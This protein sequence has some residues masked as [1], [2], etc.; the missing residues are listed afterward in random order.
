MDSVK[1]GFKVPEEIS[2]VGND[3][4]LQDS[5]YT[6]ELTTMDVQ[7]KLMAQYAVRNLVQLMNGE[8]LLNPVL[9]LEG[10]LIERHSVCTLTK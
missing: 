1:R 2:I 3:N 9:R 8:N 6:R 7:P 10:Q 4:F 5:S